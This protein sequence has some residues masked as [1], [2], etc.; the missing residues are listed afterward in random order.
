MRHGSVLWLVAAI[1]LAATTQLG[2]QWPAAK[3]PVIPEADGY[4]VIP[5]AAIPPDASHIYKAVFDAKTADPNVRA[6]FKLM[7]DRGASN[8]M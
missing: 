1:V 4:V 6:G 5:N 8:V 3:A 7:P 2:A